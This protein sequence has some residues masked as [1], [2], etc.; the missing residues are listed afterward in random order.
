MDVFDLRNRLVS[1]Y[2]DYTRSFIKIGDRR[3]RQFVDSHLAGEGFWPQPLLQLNPTFKPGGTIDDLVAEG[4]LH[5]ECSRVF[6]IGKSDTDHRGKQLLLHRHQRD[7]ILEAAKGRSYVLT[8][9]TG[10]GKSLAYIVPIV[11]HVLRRGSGRGV[12]A[13]IVYPMNALAN[14]QDEELGKFVDKGYAEGRSP[15]RFARYTGQERG[16]AREAIRSDPPDILLTNYMMLELLLTRTEDRELLRAAQGLRFLVFDELHTYRGR[17]GAD[18]AMLI[19]RCR[20]AVGNSV[21]CIG[22]SATMASGG[23]SEEQRREVAGVSQTLFGVP[24]APEQVVTES[25]ERA[26]PEIELADPLIRAAIRAAVVSDEE[27]PVEYGTFCMHPLAS[28]IESTFGVREE[29]DT[30]RLLRQTPRRLEGDPIGDVPS[31]A[32]ELAAL[33]E[34]DPERCAEALR[35]WLLWGSSL[36]DDSSRFSIFAFRLHQFLTRGDT[37]WAS[38]E[39]EADRHLEIAK[40][41][42]KPGEPD[43]PLFPLVFCR[44]CGTAYY[45]VWVAA[46]EDDRRLLPRED[47]REQVDDGMREAYLHLSK[48][49]PWPRAAG[50]ELLSRLPDS[51]KETT[52]AGEER[53]RSNARQDVPEP[54]FVAPSGRI[55][56]EGEGVPA[57]LLYRNFLF[58]LEPS[59]GVTYTRTQ[60]SERFKLATLGVDSRSTATTILAVRS[61]ITLQRE[62]SLSPEARKLLSFTDNRQDASLQAGHFNDFVQVALLRSALYAACRQ[63]GLQGLGHGDLSRCVL[64]AMKPRFEDY[65]ADPAVRGPARQHTRDALRRVLEYFLYRDLERGWRVTA[66]NLEDCGLLRFEYEGLA[67]HDGLL[68]ETTLWETGFSVSGHRGSETSIEVPAELRLATADVR[69]EIVRTLLDELR[70]ALAV[71]VDVLDSE[72][73][74]D[75]VEQTKPRLLEDTVWHLDDE[76]DLTSARIAWPRPQSRG[77]RADFFVSSRGAYGQY[78]KR[79]LLECRASDRTLRGVDIDEIIRFLF[80]A[81]KRY[82]IVEQVRTASGGDDPGYQLN[83]GALRWLVGDGQGAPDRIRVLDEGGRPAEVNR[84]FAECYCRFV[85]LEC[86]LEA[87]E[88]TAQVTSGERQEREER[89]R[90]G[91]L[92]LLFCSPTMELGVD[93]AQLNLVNLRNVPPTPANY[94]QRSGRAGRGGQPALVFTYCAGRSPHDQYFYREPNRMVAGA[95]APPRID[96]RNRDLVRSHIHAIW[97]ESAHLDLGK[98]LTAILDLEAT[99]AALPLPVK[100]ALG[101]ELRSPIHRGAARARADAVVEEIRAELEGTTWFQDGWTDDVLA[102]LERSFDSACERWRTLYR[103][104]VRQRGLHHAIIGDHSRPD[105]ERNHSRRLRAQAESQIRLLTEAEGVYEGDFYSYRYFAT[106]G[107]LPGYNFPRLPIS[108]YVPGRRKG[109]GRDEFIS[110][111]RFLAISEF[112]PRAL[113]YHEGARYRV[114]KVNLDFGS[115]AVEDSHQI[116]TARMKRCGRCGYAHLQAGDTHLSE[117][118]ERCGAALDP[119][120][121]IDGLVQLQNVSLKLAQRITCDEEERRRYGYEL[122]AAYRFPEVGSQV[123]RRD[124]DVH[125]GGARVITLS[126]ADATDLYRVNLGWLNQGGNQPRGFNLD[127]ERG[128]WSRNQA[129]ADD[130]DDAANDG[131][132]A[133]V[134]PFVRDTRNAVVMRFDPT[135]SGPE[136]MSLQAAFKEAIQRHFQL[137]PRELAAE[138][139]PSRDDQREILFYEASEGGAGVLRQ[140]AEDPAVVPALARQALEICHYAPGTLED[141]AVDRCGKACYECLLDYGNQ[142]DHRHLDRALIRD[143]LAELSHADCKPAGGAGTRAERLVAL[144]NRC[145]SG[146]ERQWLDMVDSLALRLPSDAQYGIPQYRTRPDFFYREANAAIYVDGPPHDVPDQVRA[147]EATTRRL[148]EAGYIVLRFHH[149]ADWPAL[150]RQHAD[151]FGAPVHELN[152]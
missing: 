109:K 36:R 88:H 50:C 62:R 72:K 130:R 79:R 84:Y 32:A 53:I 33:V 108:A 140:L 26:T 103:A 51:L 52:T 87:R 17:Q 132:I 76:R 89:F 54:V 58:C 24:I 125:C 27:P 133:R 6:R 100:S 95:V 152:R 48:E 127:L 3:I 10:S 138:A 121:C 149:A 92:P 70:R 9:G 83:A 20:H 69:E 151:V 86:A 4:V 35:R 60:R 29:P 82:G 44:R 14:S 110:R 112:G 122:V 39:P 2:R 94:A 97:M 45:R 75:L 23:G 144:R 128:Y 147:D 21:V 81:L 139:M 43:K 145:D 55:V 93:I 117:V 99:D 59:C 37:V 126:Y 129:D 116:T 34:S 148:I 71:K 30:G 40:K 142:P 7:A 119:Q 134:V 22:T 80:L 146:L 150:F 85:D 68:G 65:A 18:I 96:L 15:V 19:R 115:D 102:Q 135:R 137:E 64:D 136:L 41:A 11:D 105:A 46:D 66:P 104:A 47:R 141:L 25:L 107:F 28:W 49:A 73:R 123:D 98:T 5:E 31:A 38:L 16:P 74:H 106:E 91:K 61:L 143:L 101:D 78:V 8:T 12:Q 67:G 77:D 113:I 114:Y 13:I 111:P 131:R 57:A 90:E 120:S 63:A 56:P 118:C 42:A 124:A 1:D